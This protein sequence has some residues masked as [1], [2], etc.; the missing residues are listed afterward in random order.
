VKKFQDG[1][2]AWGRGGELLEF[3]SWRGCL[4]LTAH[5]F[6]VRALLVVRDV[7]A[8]AVAGPAIGRQSDLGSPVSLDPEACARTLASHQ[9]IA[10]HLARR[11][12][13]GRE[14]ASLLCLGASG[15][16]RQR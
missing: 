16:P 6:F 7:P 12:G 8:Q 11:C 14:I 10:A 5:H 2:Q 3:G 15:A 13:Q 4:Q 1:G 9:L